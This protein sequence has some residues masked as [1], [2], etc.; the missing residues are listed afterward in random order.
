MSQPLERTLKLRELQTSY[1]YTTV[2]A[3]KCRVCTTPYDSQAGQGQYTMPAGTAACMRF[4]WM[5]P[6]CRRCNFK[7]AFMLVGVSHCLQDCFT[8]HHAASQQGQYD[9]GSLD[10]EAV[11]WGQTEGY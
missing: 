6:C 7:I 5:S 9:S 2:L 1:V 10:M 4:S 11:H 3:K 8:C